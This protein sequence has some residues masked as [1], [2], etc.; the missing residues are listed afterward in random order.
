[1]P[2]VSVIMPCFNASKYLGEAIESVQFQSYKDW[3]L[4]IVDDGSTDNSR[5]I[6]RDYITRDYRIH[7]IE[8]PNSGACQARNNGIEHARGEYIKFLDADDFLTLDCLEN[9]VHQI[10]MLS[11]R[12]IPFGDYR[13]IDK[14]GN[15]LSTYVFNQQD[16]LTNDPV[17]FFFNEWRILISSPLHRIS[18][19]REIHGFDEELPRGQESDLHLRLALADVEFVYRPGMTFCYRDNNAVTRISNNFREGSLRLRQYR[20]MR[21]HKCEQCFIEKYG[22]VPSPYHHYFANT[23]FDLAREYFAQRNTEKGLQYLNK[24]KVYGLCSFFQKSYNMLGSLFGYQRL[25]YMLRVRLKL[26]NKK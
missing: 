11:P 2:K 6:V 14:D 21:A 9:Q 20:K 7:L 26:L 13:N 24:A 25:E 12:Q 4:L 3:E 16:N 19:L 17:L 22:I 15:I 8:Q 5:E 10:I 18:L 23:W 1:M